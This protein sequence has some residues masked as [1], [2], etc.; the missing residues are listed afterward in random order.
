VEAER[1]VKQLDVHARH[2]E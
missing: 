2:Y 1:Q